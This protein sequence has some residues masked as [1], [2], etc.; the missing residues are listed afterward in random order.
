MFQE[1]LESTI[2]VGVHQGAK[3]YEFGDFVAKQIP[4]HLLQEKP[5]REFFVAAEEPSEHT[6]YLLLDDQVPPIQIYFQS[7]AVGEK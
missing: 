1:V 5:D 7:L 6:V 3:V 4:A 2:R